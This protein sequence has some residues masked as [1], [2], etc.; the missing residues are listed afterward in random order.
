MRWLVHST[1][2]ECEIYLRGATF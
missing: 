1:M 2:T